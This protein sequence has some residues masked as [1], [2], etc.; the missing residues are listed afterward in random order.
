MTVYLDDI[1]VGTEYQSTGR[2]ITVTDIAVF[3]ELTGD[4]NP[5]HLDEEWVRANTDYD[6]CI[7][8]GLL[9]LAISSGLKTEGLDDWHIEGYLGEQR[10]MTAPTY[11]G[12]TVQARSVVTEVRR[13]NSRPD[14]GI[15]TV[16]VELLKQDG[17]VVQSG[18]DTYLVGAQK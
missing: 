8:H 17:T 13:S 7:A 2:T 6:G 5:L 11:P 1:E 10:R 4:H 3:A 15:V 16:E 12:D 18:T 9:M 14:S